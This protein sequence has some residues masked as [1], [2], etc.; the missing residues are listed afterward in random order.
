[1]NMLLDPRVFQRLL[2]RHPLCGILRQQAVDEVHCFD[3]D[4]LPILD[5]EAKLAAVD[6]LVDLG[7]AFAVKRGV[8]TQQEIGDR[9]NGPQVAGLV[10]LLSQNL[11]GD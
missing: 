2:R 1:M 9:T 6:G 7:V 10:V 8:S 11:G 4:V 5:R 3:A